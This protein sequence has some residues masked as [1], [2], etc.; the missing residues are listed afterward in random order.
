MTTNSPMATPAGSISE[1][2][3]YAI[4]IDL[5]TTNTAVAYLDRWQGGEPRVLPL[6]QWET[7]ALRGAF[8]LLPS[9]V[10]LPPKAA[11]KRGQLALPWDT[12]SGEAAPPPHFAVG[13]LARLLASATPGRV[14]HSAKSWLSH[15]GIDPEAAILPWQSEEVPPDERWSPVAVSAALLAHVRKAFDAALA[16][17][18]PSAAFDLQDIVITVPASFDE[19]AQRLTLAAAAQA[20]YPMQRLRLV[21]EPLAAF[22]DWLGGGSVDQ[23]GAGRPSVLVV[24]MGGGT[25]DFSLFEVEQ[26]LQPEAGPVIRRTAVSDHLLL[27]GDNLD[28]AVA[29]LLEPRLAGT[30]GRLTNAAWQDL[31][32]QA[33]AVKERALERSLDPAHDEPLHVA[34]AAAG[35]SLF[36]GVRSATATVAEVQAKILDGFF[37]VVS[38]A[39]VPDLSR[40][41]L[42]SLGLP[43]ARDTAVTRHLAAFLAGRS[44]DWVLFAGGSLRP[45]ALRQRLLAVLSHWQGTPPREL[46]GESLD[47]AVARGA[48][49]LSAD[50]AQKR[51]G[52]ALPIGGGY[53][54]SLYLEVAGAA[55]AMSG[56]QPRR[57]VCIVPKGYGE[58]EAPLRTEHPGLTVLTGTTCR[59][60]VWSSARRSGDRVGAVVALDDADFVRL[61]PLRARIDLGQAKS[62]PRRL[63]VVL[64]ARLTE[65]GIL[66]LAVTAVSSGGKE[67]GAGRFVLEF[68]VRGESHKQTGG[69]Q[70]QVPSPRV[71]PQAFAAATTRL[72]TLFGKTRSAIDGDA[73]P[74]SLARDLESALDLPREAWDLALARRLYE[75]LGA[76]TNRRGR[77]PAHEATFY[78][79]AGYLLRPG[80]GHAQD[81]Q[82]V[83]DLAAAILTSGMIHPRERSVEEQWW[84]MWRRIAGGL[85]R[86]RQ[87]LLL[88]RILPALRKGDL[89]SPEL[90]L[91]AGALE[92]ADLG[93]K[94]RLGQLL[95]QQLAAGRRQHQDAR[96][97]A[98]ARVASRS[99]LYGGPETVVAPEVVARWWLELRPL[100]TAAAARGSRLPL[101]LASAGRLV[102]E[103]SLDLT[104]GLREEFVTVL[105]QFGAGDDLIRPLREV[106]PVSGAAREA[107]FGESLPLGLSLDE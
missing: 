102:G 81:E 34:V 90:Y 19:R 16:V 107:Q 100:A 56:A 7:E 97:F 30:N 55:S 39:D 91:L 64:D 74:K 68:G 4:G 105:R 104:D 76:G 11:W 24:D 20:G 106:I 46:K 6:L 96:L 60:A 78:N 52:A 51:Q 59:F 31:V 88:A 92:R 40:S 25:T 103:R 83:G 26:A 66:E 17:D 8:A 65:T 36:A 15:S 71:S 47:L 99:P 53:G 35:S 84:I 94:M 10:Y 42:R 37:P 80:Y 2:P 38:A 54:R 69:E 82:V 98:L 1:V 44:V 9:M 14:A 12:V 61:S 73:K 85:S 41:G 43:Y 3:R 95:T 33:R 93:Q 29:H 67:S 48:A 50:H 13:R 86:E 89:D 18:D 79:L 32:F 62:A 75:P 28:L 101:F 23:L 63:P 27:G 70:P 77:T 58:G 57:A 22:R 72:E 21:E 45:S 5:G 49:R 87:D